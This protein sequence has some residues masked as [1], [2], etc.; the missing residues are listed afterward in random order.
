M[1]NKSLVISCKL[2]Q[3]AESCCASVASCKLIK[4]DGGNVEAASGCLAFKFSVKLYRVLVV[5]NSKKVKLS[6]LYRYINAILVKM[7]HHG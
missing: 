2:M 1:A 4:Q 3:S 7:V 5:P 6:I